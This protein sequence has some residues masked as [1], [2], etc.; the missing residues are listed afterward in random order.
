MNFRQLYFSKAYRLF[1]LAVFFTG[2]PLLV[3]HYFEGWLK[4]IPLFL[5]TVIFLFLL[6]KD[7]G[8]DKRI[9]YRFDVKYARKSIPRLVFVV[10]VGIVVSWA[11]FPSLVFEYPP[12]HI[13]YLI[14]FF[15]YPIISVLPQELIFRVYF[16]H[17]FKKLIPNP[18]LLMF[19]N[20]LV[21]SL[22]HLIYGNITAPVATFVLG[23][24]FI[25]NYTK[26]KSLLNVSLEHCFYGFVFFAVGLI[27]FFY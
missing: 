7:P 4:F 21:F 10:V 2:I 14:A 16:F 20:A 24:I 19:I 23:W 18:Y 3:D 15:S 12:E 8:F 11:L 9:L 1:E 5:I 22:A 27:Y 26:T 17:R 13:E 25:L 6:L